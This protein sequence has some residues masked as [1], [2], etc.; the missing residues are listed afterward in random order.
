[1]LLVVVLC[2]YF[3]NNG[4][5]PA[6]SFSLRLGKGPIGPFPFPPRTN[7]TSLEQEDPDRDMVSLTTRARLC[8]EFSLILEDLA[9][10]V[11]L[12]VDERGGNR[13]VGKCGHCL[14]GAAFLKQLKP[15]SQAAQWAG[16]SKVSS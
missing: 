15:L 16:E 14:G 9:C 10:P 6:Q 13:M 3:L 8:R 7:P 2:I 1:M 5:L 4:A 12:D 11:D